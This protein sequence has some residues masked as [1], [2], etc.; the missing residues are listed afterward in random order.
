MRR[1][2]S[3]QT[4]RMHRSESSRG[5]HVRRDGS[6]AAILMLPTTT[7]VMVRPFLYDSYCPIFRVLMTS[8][9]KDVIS[10]GLN[11]KKIAFGN[12]EHTMDQK[13][14]V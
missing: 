3:D 5:I 9:S 10:C 13:M 1:E 7:L 14:G 8:L 2:D 11:V 4:A 12:K 6:D